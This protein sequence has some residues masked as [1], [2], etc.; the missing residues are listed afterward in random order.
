MRFGSLKVPIGYASKWDLG[1][2]VH[3]RYEASLKSID[4]KGMRKL[5][6]FE[7]LR[8]GASAILL[9]HL[10][11][12]ALPEGDSILT[13]TGAGAGRAVTQVVGRYFVRRLR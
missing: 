12:S 9:V 1:N 10:P 6:D 7:I 5:S 8:S 13:V 3:S 11:S 4:G 2:D